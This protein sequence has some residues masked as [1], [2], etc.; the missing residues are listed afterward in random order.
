MRR[1]TLTTTLVALLLLV[2]A[3]VARAGWEEGVAAFKAGKYDQAAQEFSA[4]VEKQPEYDGGQYMLGLTLLKL[5]RNAPAL[6]A[7]KKAYELQ[8]DKVAYQIALGQAYLA[9]Q[10]Y[11]DAAGMLQRI[12]PAS[13]PKSQQASYQQ[14]LALALDK[15]GNSDAALGA[16]KKITESSPNDADAWYRYGTAAFNA[17]QTS[18]AVS[19]LE[20]S[21]RL[22]GQDLRKREA[23]AKALVRQAREAPNGDRKK[24][25]YGH[26]VQVA[27][28][29]ATARPDYD[30][31]L[32]LGELQLGA[33][34]Y[35]DAVQTLKKAAAKGGSAW[36]PHYYMAQAYTL[37]GQ[38]DNADSAA[39][40]ALQKAQDD[41]ARKMVWRQIGFAK[42]KMKQFDAAREAYLKGGDP[43]S[44]QRVQEN[45]KI[46]QENKEIEAENEEIRQMEEER[47]KLEQQLKDLGG[48]PHR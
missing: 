1:T 35:Q 8:P 41:K 40:S 5:D 36:Y 3:G 27:D 18:Q 38:Y 22:D 33:A 7:L 14:M 9:N 13:L 30:N 26:A 48:P 20:S 21:V 28:A 42:E 37:L 4:V 10:R 47:K 11:K 45:Q 16:L 39:Q 19:A 34:E 6:A 32:L 25:I 29:L 44:A 46:S 43:Q 24:A 12:N 15:S 31:L 17:G 2:G 23:L